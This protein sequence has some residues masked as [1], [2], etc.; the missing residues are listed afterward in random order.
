MAGPRRSL[1]GPPRGYRNAIR[2]GSGRLAGGCLRSGIAYARSTGSR[3]TSRTDIRS[4]SWSGCALPEHERP[5]SRRR[6]RSAPRALPDLGGGP[7]RA[8]G[9]GRG[10]HQAGRPEPD[11][12]AP[13]PGDPRPPRRPPRP[14]LASRSS[15]RRGA[16]LPHRPPGGGTKDRRRGPAVHLRATGDPGGRARQAGGRATRPVQG[17]CVLRRG[18]RRDARDHSTRGRLRAPHQPDPARTGNLPP[19]SALQGVRAAPHV[20]VVPRQQDRHMLRRAK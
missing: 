8:D 18:A 5:Q 9:G 16:R 2:S 13:H 4:P 20:P 12:G 1:P 10:G 14:R 19:P 11:Q 3:S 15:A 6:L 17:E 7:R